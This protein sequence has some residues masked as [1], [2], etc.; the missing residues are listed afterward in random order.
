MKNVVH[1]KV[2]V[3]GSRDFTDYKK[4]C[5]VLD[6]YD[7]HE[8]VSGGA[9]GADSL[10]AKYAKEHGIGLTEFFPDWS[11]GKHAGHV[12]NQHIIDHCDIVFAF[13]DMESKGTKD[14]IVKAKKANKPVII[15]NV[16][17]KGLDFD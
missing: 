6:K 10:A 12:R 3:I 8:I 2:A 1:E 17:G 15:I 4:L 13:W 16:S 7:I 11:V 14:S 9:R 5:E